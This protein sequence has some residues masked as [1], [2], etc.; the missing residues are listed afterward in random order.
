[1]GAVRGRL[2]PPESRT[3]RSK[4]ETTNKTSS[5]KATLPKPA[6]QKTETAKQPENTA[7]VNKPAPKNPVADELF[8]QAIEEGNTARDLRDYISAESAYRRAEGIKPKDSRA[9]YGVGNLYSDQ[10]RWEEAE[11]NSRAH[12]VQVSTSA[13]TVHVPNMRRL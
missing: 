7:A 12:R 5:Q 8:E 2:R 10:Q 1:M 4:P 6:T 3:T 9:I 13:A 11:Q